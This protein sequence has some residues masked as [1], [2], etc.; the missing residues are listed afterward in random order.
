MAK[1]KTVCESTCEMN[2]MNTNPTQEIT[3]NM[4]FRAIGNLEG[5][6]QQMDGKIEDMQEVQTS[7][8]T[9]IENI[10]VVANQVQ[11]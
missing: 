10:A 7:L 11:D 8:T 1:E 4:V 3:L 2:S 9:K 6:V 5:T